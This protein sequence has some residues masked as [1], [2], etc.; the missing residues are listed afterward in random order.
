MVLWAT[1]RNF[2]AWPSVSQ[3]L[4]PPAGRRGSDAIPRIYPNVPLLFTSN[5]R[6]ASG[7]DGCRRIPAGRQVQ[8]PLQRDRRARAPVVVERLAQRDPEEEQEQRDANSDPP[9]DHL[10][11]ATAAAALLALHRRERRHGA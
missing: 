5:G 1:P 4:S 2:A 11:T 10:L 7:G 9:A 3:S 6:G 8:R